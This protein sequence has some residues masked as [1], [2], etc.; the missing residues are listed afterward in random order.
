MAIS[1]RLLW[2]VWPW[3][4]RE[5]RRAAFVNYEARRLLAIGPR[6]G[7]DTPARE[8]LRNDLAWAHVADVLEVNRL[9]VDK[10]H[11]AKIDYPA[12]R[13]LLGKSMRGRN[14]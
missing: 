2:N 9:P 13:E 4:T 12:L 5:L 14:T 6:A 7:L 11:N 10:R 3:S 8:A 1:T